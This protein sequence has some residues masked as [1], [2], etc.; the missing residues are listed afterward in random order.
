MFPLDPLKT[1]KK[2]RITYDRDVPQPS[3]AE[4]AEDYRDI[5]SGN[6]KPVEDAA[7]YKYSVAACYITEM[8]RE[9][10]YSLLSL[11]S[12]LKK[13]NLQ[14]GFFLYIPLDRETII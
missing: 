2:G 13:P 9:R 3:P 11:I 10:I 12:Y 14:F 4:K 1:S 8:P 6:I 5:V 7:P